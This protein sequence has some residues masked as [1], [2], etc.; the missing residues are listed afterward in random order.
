VRASSDAVHDLLCIH[1][2]EEALEADEHI[3]LAC[4]WLARLALAACQ[5]TAESGTLKAMQPIPWEPLDPAR[6]RGLRRTQP[7]PAHNF[8]LPHTGAGDAGHVSDADLD[9]YVREATWLTRGHEVCG[10][11]TL[12]SDTKARELSLDPWHMVPLGFGVRLFIF[13]AAG[14]GAPR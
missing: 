8:A 5:S 6:M 9:K 11:I 2:L 1:D 13:P 3:R 14:E 4:D 10:R 7:A 12:D